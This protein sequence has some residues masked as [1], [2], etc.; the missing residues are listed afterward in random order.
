[1]SRHE[2]DLIET[3]QR[4]AAAQAIAAEGRTLTGADVVR[5]RIALSLATSALDLIKVKSLPF[6]TARA[7]R[8]ARHALDETSPIVAP[9]ASAPGRARPDTT[10]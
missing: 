3:A 7:I 10:P 6:S 4:E 2:D 5:L 8:D 1:M 9:V